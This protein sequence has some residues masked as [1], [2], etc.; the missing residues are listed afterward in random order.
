MLG[1]DSGDTGTFGSAP[2]L[3]GSPPIVGIG[4]ANSGAVGAPVPEPVADGCTPVP[5]DVNVGVLQSMRAPCDT[6]QSQRNP[7]RNTAQ[8]ST[9]QYATTQRAPPQCALLR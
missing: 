1:A 3:G 5:A 2:E 6:H 8:L 9:E 7:E 4:G